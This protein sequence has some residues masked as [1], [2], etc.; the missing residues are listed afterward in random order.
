MIADDEIRITLRLPAWMRDKIAASAKASDRSMNGEILAVL[1]EKFPP[2]VV[3]RDDYSRLESLADAVH[4]ASKVW[5][6]NPRNREAFA[7][8]QKLHNE[9]GELLLELR[10]RRLSKGK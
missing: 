2:D 4:K 9:M 8:W 5:E 10:S 6:A 3:S 1:G 7:R